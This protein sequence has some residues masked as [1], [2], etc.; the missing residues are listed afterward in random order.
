MHGS[1]PV[2]ATLAQAAQ[3]QPRAYPLLPLP[4]LL[5][6]LPPPAGSHHA[7]CRHL[8]SDLQHAAT[9]SCYARCLVCC[10]QIHTGIQ[11][12]WCGVEIRAHC[13]V[14]WSGLRKECACANV[15][16]ARSMAGP[17][18]ATLPGSAQPRCPAHLRGGA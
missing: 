17:A 7:L 9:C 16:G 4:Q 2:G 11:T 18:A 5:L 1:G 3:M 14:H 13:C 6:H 10:P 12:S 8:H 15:S